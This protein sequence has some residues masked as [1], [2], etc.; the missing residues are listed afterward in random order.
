MSELVAIRGDDE[1]YD[2]AFKMPDGV[3]P[4]NLTGAQG[5]WFTAKRSSLDPDADALIQKALGAGIAI[6][7][8]PAGTATLTIDAA[9]TA[10]IEP[11]TLV[12]DAQVKD[13]LTK[14]RTA[15]KGTLVIESDVT[16]ATA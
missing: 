7:S 12:W 10:D 2:I 8:A 16:R 9:D 15:A 6:V 4:L 14:I 1:I 3:T 13:S 11:T 5:I